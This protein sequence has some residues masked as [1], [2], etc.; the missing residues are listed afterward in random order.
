MA[1]RRGFLGIMGG[2]AAAGPKL[3]TSLAAEAANAPGILGRYAVGGEVPAMS[4]WCS[5]SASLD[6]KASRIA[7]LEREEA[8]NRMHWEFELSELTGGIL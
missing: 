7:T 1:T 2:A 6:Y 4:N 3:A 8:I 5:P